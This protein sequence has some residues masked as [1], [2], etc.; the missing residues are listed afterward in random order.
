M[1]G[2]TPGKIANVDINKH[3]EAFCASFIR[4]EFRDRWVY[5]L[6]DRPDKG[7][8]QL[9]KF[10]SH[11]D[12]RYCQI[13]DAADLSADRLRNWHVVHPVLV[14]TSRMHA[15]EILPISEALDRNEKY[16]EDAVVSLIAGVL[17]VVSS[18]DGPYW[19]CQRSRGA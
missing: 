16:P 8:T 4:K 11:H 19:I 1:K 3:I 18:H 5:W 12:S 17:A 2:H 14:F 13:A 9:H 15:P 6:R 10:H 7:R